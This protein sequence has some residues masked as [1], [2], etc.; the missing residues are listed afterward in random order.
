[1]PRS[2]ILFHHVR[3]TL[4]APHSRSLVAAAAAGAIALLGSAAARAQNA[5]TP[6]A[7]QNGGGDQLQ[8]VIVTA[9]FR[10]ENVQQTPL[11]ITAINSSM[12]AQRGQT[13]LTQIAN[14]VPSVTLTQDAA[15]F[16]PTMAAYVR[17]IG[18]YDLDPALE[19][20]VGIYID[21]VYFGTL[22]GS[23]LDLLDLDRVEVLRGP[24]GT[25]AGMNSEGGAV[26]LFTKKPDATPSADVSLLYGSRNHIEARAST[27]FVL[28]PDH[29]FVRMSGVANHQDGYVDVYDFGCAN[30]SFTA[31]DVNGVTG[32]FSVAPNFLT[33][34][35]SCR[36]GQEGGIGYAAGRLALRWVINDNLEANI[37][38]DFTNENQENPATTLLFAGIPEFS[39]NGAPNPVYSS[40]TLATTN[41]DQL[42]YDSARVPAMIP[43]NPYAAYSSFSIPAFG[44]QP[45]YYGEDRTRLVSWGVAATIDWKLSDTMSL[46]SIT[47]QRGYWSGW[48]EDNDA[49]AWPIGLGGE[50]LEHHQ[51]SEELRFNG[52]VGHL[53]DYTLGGFYFRELSVY[54]THQDLWYAAGPG[55]LNFLGQ[56]P[57]LAH[58]YAGFLH[59]VWHLTD[60]LDFNAGV[61]YTSQ[62]KDY[63]FVRVAP[64]G[65]VPALVGSLNGVTSHYSKSR[66]DYRGSVDYHFT[67][68]LMGYAQV[69]TGFK[70]GGINP[71]PFFP[72]QAT[73]GQFQPET[74]TNYE[75][76]VKSTWL[77]NRLRVNVDGYFSQYRNI[78]LALLNCDFLNPPPFG[79][80]AGLPCALPFNA[81]DAHIKGAELETQFRP[82]SGLEIDGSG[83]YLD[84]EYVHLSTLP[85]GV[86]LDMVSP[87]TPKWQGNLGVQYTLPIGNAGTITPRIE[88]SSRSEVW[89]NAVNGPNNRVGGYTL[90]NARVTWESEKGDWQATV[91]AFNLGDKLYYLNVFDLSAVGGGSVT[92]TPGRP[93]DVSLEIKHSL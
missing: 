42:P 80:N 60:K 45:A 13:S 76:G 39:P 82:I 31:T 92:G 32:T 16:G 51:T 43:S 49:S 71:R 57:I 25:L 87:F 23:L 85:T 29:L 9:Q 18:Q 56:D 19:P 46:K 65:S 22:T 52:S 4:A 37:T 40:V 90:Y 20:G 75:A 28:I 86:T 38:G 34:A 69:S 67:D 66:V 50:N 79:P 17:G 24:Q 33:H 74:L 21:D 93:L 44:N 53:M 1:M 41:G 48:Y 73:E 68:D 91:Q 26:K 5:G 89:T 63:T 62:D 64:D 12:L 77:D 58:D 88:L 54:G 61:R 10:S 72:W 11:A 78:Q 55:V 15:A 3:R 59:T 47:S 2:H 84:F 70:G 14:D 7:A 30:P 8:E 36:T 81:G 6:Q 27:D 83:S 35:T